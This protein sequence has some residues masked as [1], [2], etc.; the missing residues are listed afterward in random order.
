M[1]LDTYAGLFE[2]DLDG[3]ASRLNEAA[4][5]VRADSLRTDTPVP[6]VATAPVGGRKCRLT[7]DHTQWGPVAEFH[8]GPRSDGE[9]VTTP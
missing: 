7:C 9:S 2:D 8:H 5:V 6:H 4:A 3:V 1:T